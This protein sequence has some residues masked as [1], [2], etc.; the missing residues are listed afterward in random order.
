MTEFIDA[1]MHHQASNLR[2]VP[3][4][5]DPWIFA[6]WGELKNSTPVDNTIAD[7]PIYT[8]RYAYGGFR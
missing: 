1:Y 7:M 2:S 4:S 8:I 6:I 3:G 5:K